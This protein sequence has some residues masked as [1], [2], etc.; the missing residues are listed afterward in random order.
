MEAERRAPSVHGLGGRAG[1]RAAA[2]IAALPLVLTLPSCARISTREL[3]GSSPEAWERAMR[4]LRLES[5]AVPNPIAFNDE[6]R[7]VAHDATGTGGTWVRLERLQAYLFD[8][9]RFPFAYETRGTLTAEQAFAQR[10]GNC[11][12][13]TNL[14][15]AL[16][17]SVGIP[18]RAAV[19]AYVG[20]SEREGDLVVITTH[21]VAA[22]GMGDQLAIFDFDRTRNRPLVG[23][24]IVGDLRLSAMYQNNLGVE[25]LRGAKLDE[26]LRRLEAATRLS[27][28]FADAWGNLGVARRRSGDSDGAL[29]AYRRALELEPRNPTVLGNLATLYRG[30][31]KHREADAA[32]LGADLEEASPFFVL[33]RGDIELARGRFRAAMRLYRQ[34]RRLDPELADPLVRIARAHLARGDRAA[35]RRAAEEALSLDPESREAAAILDESR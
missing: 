7:R 4:Q 3:A 23:A 21:V 6:M 16:S 33:T 17:R 11:L 35:A 5:S 29:E 1:S 27:P 19:P 30:L 2:L 32:L 10:R 14:F 15:I 25:A 24:K 9:E 20:G 8:A 12:S 18:V 28:D 22:I 31:G 13:F 26:A 34:A